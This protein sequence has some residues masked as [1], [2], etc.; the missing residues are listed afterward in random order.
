VGE[1]TGYANQSRAVYLGLDQ[2]LI[3]TVELTLESPKQYEY[4]TKLT[5][6]FELPRQLKNSKAAPVPEDPAQDY[7]GGPGGLAIGLA[8]KGRRRV[9]DIEECPLG[10]K[11]INKKLATERAR[12]Q[13]YVDGLLSSLN[14]ELIVLS[15]NALVSCFFS[16]RSIRS[17]GGQHYYSGNH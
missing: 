8:E 17:R 5:P 2:S 12:V 11:T 15:E 14:T 10:T 9:I 3:P 1:V 13:S 16:V 6:H 7:H 4:R